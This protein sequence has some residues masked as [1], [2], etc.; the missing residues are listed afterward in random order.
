M[1]LRR[2]GEAVSFPV[3]GFDGGSISML[4]IQLG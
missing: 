2:A 3:D 4:T 1:A